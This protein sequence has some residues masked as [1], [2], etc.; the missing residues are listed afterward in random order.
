VKAP[1]NSITAQAAFAAYMQSVSTTIK[2]VTGFRE[3][4]RGLQS[5][6]IFTRAT[7]SQQANPKGIKPW[8]AHSDP[9]WVSPDPKRR[10]IS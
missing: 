4:V 10:R 7:A 9:D 1:T 5:E 3:A 6:G 8:R 2:E